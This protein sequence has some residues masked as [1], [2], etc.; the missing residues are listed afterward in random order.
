MKKPDEN[1]LVVRQ[2]IRDLELDFAKRP[3][4]RDYGKWLSFDNNSVCTVNPLDI[5]DEEKEVLVKEAGFDS[6]ADY[7]THV[8]SITF[9]TFEDAEKIIRW[10]EDDGTKKGLLKLIRELKRGVK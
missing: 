5:T 10:K 6:V 7:N 2:N 3:R 4:K 9:A 8:R 1:L